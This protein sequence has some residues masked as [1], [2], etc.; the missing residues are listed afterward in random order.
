MPDSEPKSICLAVLLQI[1][2]QHFDFDRAV[3]T[4]TGCNRLLA[5]RSRQDRGVFLALGAV[6]LVVLARP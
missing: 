6:D 1:L 2:R 5:V 3:P 4:R